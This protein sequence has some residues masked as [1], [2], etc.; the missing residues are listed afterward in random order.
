MQVLVVSKIAKNY[1]NRP[2]KVRVQETDDVDTLYQLC[3]KMSGLPQEELI[4]KYNR[5][6]YTLRIISGWSFDFYQIKE[7]GVLYIE[8]VTDQEELTELA[9]PRLNNAEITRKL[10][11]LAKL[12]NQGLL[13]GDYDQSGGYE[14]TAN[15]PQNPQKPGKQKEEQL[16]QFVTAI[17]KGEAEF[18][19]F[20]Q[21]NKS[22][23]EL[24]DTCDSNGWYPVHY[25]IN[26]SNK[27]AFAF[28]LSNSDNLNQATKEGY[29][30]LMLAANKKSP[31]NFKA[32]IESKKVDVNRI[33]KKGT[34][35]HFLCDLNDMQQYRQYIASL[36]STNVNPYAI[37]HSKRVAVDLL[38]DVELKQKLIKAYEKDQNYSHIRKKPD[39]IRGT[40]FKTGM[41]FRNL[42][43]RYLELNTNERCL[44]RYESK[45]G[46]PNKPI[47]IIPL[48]DVVSVKENSERL[49]FQHG[50]YYFEVNYDSRNIFATKSQNLTTKWVQSINEAVDY[51]L[52]YESTIK[53]MTLDEKAME[54]LSKPATEVDLDLAPI[55]SPTPTG[56]MADPKT[57]TMKVSSVKAYLDSF[58]VLRRL[59]EG[60]FGVVYKVKC[61]LNGKIY[62][63]KALQKDR[64]LLNKQLKYAQAEANILRKNNNP[65][66]LS[67][68]FAFQ[69][70]TC[71]YMVM[72]CCS[73]K[74]LSLLI[75]KQNNFTEEEARFYIAE[76]ILGV[77]Y[78]HKQGVLYRDLK[79]ENVLV[80]LDGHLMLCDFGL[81]KENVGRNE[82]A[83]SFVGSR[84][85]LSPE[86]V[87]GQG[88]SPASD[89]FAIGLLLYEMLFGDV[90]YTATDEKT[91]YDQIRNLA[92]EM[93]EEISQEAEDLILKL[94]IKDPERRLGSKN[95]EEIKRHP[96]F[97]NLDWEKMANKELVP[98][99][100][101]EEFDRTEGRGT[102]RIPDQDYDDHNK[103]FLRIAGWSFTK[104]SE[105]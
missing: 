65:F 44:I 6:G 5:D 84:L 46:Y 73:K 47:E 20:I 25:A 36:L 61:K 68:Y 98:P 23:K 62:A 94:L 3:A 102:I 77:E 93:P 37:D 71:L 50:F 72:D 54:I 19:Q 24:L 41:F 10:M 79:P 34:I 27:V 104:I 40:V 86:M 7:N 32:L 12:K 9:S 63:M 8:T 45:E 64:V 31:E 92:V 101:E 52:K 69:T 29:T 70:P 30:A 11:E 76:I 100:F 14:M 90:P 55:S 51:A 58:E 43:T 4:I 57:G 38:T 2:Q 81:S 91:L 66:V 89:I 26:Y 96:F 13:E 95:K 15:Q 48:R 49:F 75:L 59:G 33:T 88:F 74:N 28:I 103:N 67:L 22:A 17:R 78:L 97:K 16:K 83:T 21:D 87:K 53:D 35:I 42:N 80:G 60:S 18:S 85:Y 1:Y 82:L 99:L 105:V 39:A 56:M